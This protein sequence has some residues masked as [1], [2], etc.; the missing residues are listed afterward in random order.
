MR[1]L[2][3]NNGTVVEASDFRF[4]HPYVMQRIHTLGYTPYNLPRHLL[5]MREASEHLF[6]FASLCRAE[7]AERI[8][9]KL[10]SLSRVSSTL[11]VPVVMRLDA[12]GNLSFEVENP[13]YSSGAYLRAKRFAAATMELPVV[14][15]QT[16]TSA[17]EAMD[18]MA[19]AQVAVQG[20]EL[21]LATTRDEVVVGRPWSPVFVVYNGVIYTSCEYDT[22]EYHAARM[23]IAKSNIE[24]VVRPVPYSAL[25]RMEEIFVVDIMGVSSCSTIKE[26]R[27]LSAVASRVADRMEPKP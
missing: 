6:G 20:G 1:L 27:L 4:E 22:V 14:E 9:S 15:I 2:V 21:L 11:S 26:H 13:I 10:L 18:D 24:L 17:T 12:V 19:R 5:L 8:I 23:A 25:E 3:W 16:P 7:D